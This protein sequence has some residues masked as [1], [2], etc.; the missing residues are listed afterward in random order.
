MIPAQKDPLKDG[1]LYWYLKRMLRSNFHSV[2]ASGVEHL[3]GLEATRPVIAFAN[4]SNWWDGVLIFFLSRFQPKKD[5]YCMMEE[6]QM[7]HYKFLSWLG[8]FSVDL[9]NSLRA[10]GTIRYTCGLL[11]KN[12]T[13]IW[14]FPQGEMGSPHEPI[15]PRPGI[16]FL[17]KR[18]PNAQMLPMVMEFGFEREQHPVAY[19]KIGKPYVAAENSDERIETEL[20]GLLNSLN[21]EVKDR[22]FSEYETLLKTGLSMN[23]RWEWVKRFCTG[24]LKGYERE[25]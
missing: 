19:L 3:R 14:I 2:R 24:K 25:N 20:S 7:R 11:K 4:H 21:A 5:F 15:E 16:D 18:F 6:K 23:K 17:A 12:R 10:A 22:N 9:E 1:V 13:M 8:A